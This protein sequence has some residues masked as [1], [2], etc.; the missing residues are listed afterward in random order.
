MKLAIIG[1]GEFQLPLVL[2]AKE[3]GL[4]THVFAWEQGAVAKSEADYFYPISIIE[5]ETIRSKLNEIKPDAVLSICS[6][7]A[8]PTVSFLAES[9]ALTANSSRSTSLTLNKFFMKQQFIEHKIPCAQ[10]AVVS[11]LDDPFLQMLDFKNGVIIKPVDRSGSLAV[12]LV[13]DQEKATAAISKAI[14]VSFSKKCVVEEYLTGDEYS[15]ETVSYQGQH[16]IVAVTE[17]A[18][19]Q[20]PY[21]VEKSHTQPALLAKEILA[22][23]N[24]VVL[25]ALNALEIS[26]GISHVELK[27]NDSKCKIIEIGG[28]M[29]GDYIGSHLVPA[30]TGIDF[31]K[32]A[33]EIALGRFSWSSLEISSAPTPVTVAFLTHSHSE[34]ALVSDNLKV[35][36]PYPILEEQLKCHVGDTIKQTNSSCTRYGYVIYNGPKVTD[37]D[38]LRHFGLKFSPINSVGDLIE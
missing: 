12:E 19:T 5:F 34:K 10:G 38:L 13:Y 28:R 25:S 9:F 1:A 11:S 7:V 33:I 14:D 6:E 17:K 3:M 27:I 31:L 22:Q 35:S 30:S 37:Y 2:K 21:F 16:K 15:V 26:N 29:G 23:L 18:T 36:L 20:A 4:E 8:M 32:V 24:T